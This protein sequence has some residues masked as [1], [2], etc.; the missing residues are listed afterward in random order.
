MTL[1]FLPLTFL[2]AISWCI[3]PLP[4][5]D[6]WIWRWPRCV[7]ELSPLFNTHVLWVIPF[8][9]IHLKYRL[10]VNDSEFSISL[11][12]TSSKHQSLHIPIAFEVSLV[13]AKYLKENPDLSPQIWSHSLGKHQHAPNW[14]AKLCEVIF[15]T[16]FPLSSLHIESFIKSRWFY[17]QNI[18]FLWALLSIAL[19]L[20]QLTAQV[21]L[22]ATLVQSP[23]SS[24]WSFKILKQI[25]LWKSLLDSYFLKIRF[26]NPQH[27][28][29]LHI[30]RPSFLV[31][32]SC[33]IPPL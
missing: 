4:L 15:G 19:P 9:L 21:P 12:D 13:S 29:R 14:Q 31:P 23:E 30:I 27:G 32:I 18:I 6:F 16:Y 5:V 7:S 2:A 3:L 33:Y 22:L 10:Y 11:T 25:T 1:Y 28:F 20:C 17:L 24:Q 26:R 8:I